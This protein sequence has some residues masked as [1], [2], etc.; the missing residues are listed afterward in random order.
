M[1]STDEILNLRE[2]DAVGGLV[3]KEISP[4]SVIFATGDIEIRRRV[5]QS[6]DG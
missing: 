2:G 5:G 1:E 3:V 4:S 6:G